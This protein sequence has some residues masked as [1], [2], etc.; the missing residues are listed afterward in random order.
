MKVPAPA[1]AGLKF[2]LES[3]GVRGVAAQLPVPGGG[4]GEPPREMIGSLTHF[5]RSAPAL[6]VGKATMVR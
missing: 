2:P 5:L 4:A 3:P 6:T 1:V